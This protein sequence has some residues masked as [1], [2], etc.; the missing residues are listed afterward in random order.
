MGFEYMTHIDH[1]MV[2]MFNLWKPSLKQK[3]FA[4]NHTQNILLRLFEGRENK[5]ENADCFS[6]KS[7]LTLPLGKKKNKKK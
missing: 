5:L 1:Y 2:L 4:F 7:L 3:F 6:K